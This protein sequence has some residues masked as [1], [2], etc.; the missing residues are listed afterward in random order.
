MVTSGAAPLI[1]SASGAS[2][3]ARPRT[4]FRPRR[5]TADMNI[6]RTGADHAGARPYLHHAARWHTQ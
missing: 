4:P 3:P 1:V 2:G 5:Y 6:G